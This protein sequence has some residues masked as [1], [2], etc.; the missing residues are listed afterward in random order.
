MTESKRVGRKLFSARPYVLNSSK[1][2]YSSKLNHLLIPVIRFMLE[3]FDL[4][5]HSIDELQGWGHCGICGK[6]INNE[7][8]LKY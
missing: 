1:R 6:S 8:F 5:F 7:I 4:P 2:I 3:K